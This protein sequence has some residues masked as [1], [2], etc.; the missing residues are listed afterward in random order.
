[1]H[2]CP[3]SRA[4][5]VVRNNALAGSQKKRNGAR[6]DTTSQNLCSPTK[7]GDVSDEAPHGGG[8]ADGKRHQR[9]GDVFLIHFSWHSAK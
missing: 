6:N 1:M 7:S 9:R 3:R 2:S 8:N 5:A 4:L